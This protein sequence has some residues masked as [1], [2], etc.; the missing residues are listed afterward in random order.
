MNRRTFAGFTW[1]S[2]FVMS[3]LMV[4][5]LVTTIYLSFHR[6]FLRDLGERE[7]IGLE[8]YTDVLSDD[9]F[10]A[11]FR[12]TILYVAIVVPVHLVVGLGLANLL[13]RVKRGRGLGLKRPG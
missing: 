13:D 12:L 1:P 8:N 7:W 4:F 3:S 5:P 9:A 6:I 11:A 2:V 10:W